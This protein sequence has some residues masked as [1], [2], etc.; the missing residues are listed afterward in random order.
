MS[1][2]YITNEQEKQCSD[3]EREVEK[4]CFSPLVFSASGGMG[5]SATTVYK[6]LASMLAEKWNINYSCSLYWLRCWEHVSLL[7]MCV[8]DH[9]S[10]G[11]SNID[12][13]FSEGRLNIE[14]NY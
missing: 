6:K 3:D 9:P 11:S 14:S 4:A 8:R 2:C 12:L 5:P 13:A 10:S 1:Q 7:S